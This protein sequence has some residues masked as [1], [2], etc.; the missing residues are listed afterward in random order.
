MQVPEVEVRVPC[1]KGEHLVRVRV[2][3]WEH[4]VVVWSPC[5]D[6]LGRGLGL[7]AR[8]SS[9]VFEREDELRRTVVEA[10]AQI[11]VPAIPA[12]IQVPG[13]SDRRVRAAA[14]EAL[15]EIGDV[16]AV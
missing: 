14:C 12:L 5:F 11:G 10:L 13:D 6:L 1:S 8:C 3:S 4:Q 9:S 7:M 2:H 16:S 15:G